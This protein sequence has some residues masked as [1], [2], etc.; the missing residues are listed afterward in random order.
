MQFE[1]FLLDE[2]LDAAM[3]PVPRWNLGSVAGPTWDLITLLDLATDAERSRFMRTPLS[4]S[5][6]AGIEA[7]REAIGERYNTSADDVIVVT[8]A[9]EAIL[10]VFFNAAVPG[11]NVV[12][13]APCFPAIAAIPRALGLDVRSYQLRPENDWAIDLDEV[14]DL[15]DSRTTVVFLNSPHNP[16]GAV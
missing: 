8:G 12:L 2:W 7:L 5:R 4:Y 9:S 10:L 3:G 1:P 11:A 14:S 6:A 13:P 16:T 15:V